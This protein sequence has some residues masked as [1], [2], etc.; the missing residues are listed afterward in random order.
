[1]KN[2]PILLNLI[3]VLLVCALAYMHFTYRT[4]LSTAGKTILDPSHDPTDLHSRKADI[5]VLRLP[6]GRETDFKAHGQKGSQS[7]AEIENHYSDKNRS[8]AIKPQGKNLNQKKPNSHGRTEE[9][10]TSDNSQQGIRNPNKLDANVIQTEKDT[11]SKAELLENS[12]LVKAKTSGN[13]QSAVI[14]PAVLVDLDEPSL[15]TPQQDQEVQ[16]MAESFAQS[17][18]S[19]GLDASSI[20]YKELYNSEA[21]KSDQAFRAKYGERSWMNHHIQSYHMNNPEP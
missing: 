10:R 11:G 9:N 2:W 8:A 4:P 17:V 12:Q 5:E 19:S 14:H 21:L 15:L 20:Q 13:Q 3:A 6:I 7:Q 18:N 16:A 1:M